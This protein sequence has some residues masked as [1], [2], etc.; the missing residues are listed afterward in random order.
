MLLYI[1][2]KSF[3]LIIFK[4]IFR[5]KIIGR[6]NIPKTGP[7]VIVA[8]HSSLLDGFVLVSSVK[9]KITFMSAAYLFKMPFVGNILRGVGAIPVQGKGNDIKLIKNAMKVLQAGGVLGIFP[10]G[11][12]TN[13]KDDFSAK[14]GAAY[15]AVKADVPIIPMAIKGAGKALPVGAKFPKLNRIKVKIGKLISGSKKIKLNKKILED[16]VNSYMKEIY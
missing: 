12:I 7:F 4:L 13:E 14:A 16:T 3:S 6:E 10:E 15:L 5:L 11:R 1:I 8:N 9:P 2:I